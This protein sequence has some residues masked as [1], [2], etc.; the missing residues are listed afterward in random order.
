MKIFVSSQIRRYQKF[1]A[2]KNVHSWRRT[3]S[4]PIPTA[5]VDA[6]PKIGARARRNDAVTDEPFD[7]S[8]TLFR[9]A[10]SPP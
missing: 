3:G 6:K 7:G 8:T 2:D 5:G 10:R 1:M 4:P 9:E